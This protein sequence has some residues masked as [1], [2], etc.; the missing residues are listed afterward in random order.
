MFFESTVHHWKPTGTSRN[1]ASTNTFPFLGRRM[2]G[3]KSPF[4]GLT[5]S[6]IGRTGDRS[7]KSTI[8]YREIFR[9]GTCWEGRWGEGRR[10]NRNFD[11]PK[12]ASNMHRHTE[13]R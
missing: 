13:M 8:L 3:L 6:V 12:N 10:R 11:V 1:W 9:K 5:Q 7:R 4:S 2:R